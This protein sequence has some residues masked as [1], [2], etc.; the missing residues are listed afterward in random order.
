MRHGLLGALACSALFAVLSATANAQ[1]TFTLTGT[2]PTDGSELAFGYTSGEAVTLSL[3]MAASFSDNSSSGFF[4]TF[5]FWTEPGS[6]GGPQ[7]WTNVTG[8]GLAGAYGLSAPDGQI[9]VV[10][11]SSELAFYVESSSGGIGL[12]A[13][14]TELK[15]ITATVNSSEF[16]TFST[17]SYLNPATY[18]SGYTGTYVLDGGS[19]QLINPNLSQVDFTPTSLTITAIPEPATYAVLAGVAAL[20][21]VVLRRGKPATVD[22]G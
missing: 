20:G 3:T 16:L 12:T 2:M 21:L 10:P 11:G 6:N 22:Q 17:G 18:F 19:G 8:T 15:D 14:G 5:N 1:V 9:N 7:L 4:S 13:N